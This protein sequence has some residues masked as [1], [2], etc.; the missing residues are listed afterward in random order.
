MMQS[1]M[2]CYKVK[3]VQ[4]VCCVCV[5]CVLTEPR[6]AESLTLCKA[7]PVQGS[8]FVSPAHFPPGSK[9]SLIQS[10]TCQGRK[11]EVHS[12]SYGNKYFG[13]CFFSELFDKTECHKSA[14]TRAKACEAFDDTDSSCVSLSF[15]F[16]ICDVVI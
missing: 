11:V 10:V 5:C 15:V 1:L 3:N 13:F 8:A 14:V 4:S 6:G 2:R 16:S 7:E 9:T 12:P